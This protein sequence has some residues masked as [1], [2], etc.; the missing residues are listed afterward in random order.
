MLKYKKQSDGSIFS[1]FVNFQKIENNDD[2]L[3]KICL[4]TTE[5]LL[6]GMQ[7]DNLSE[8]LNINLTSSYRDKLEKIFEKF[9][10][11]KEISSN[12][13]L[14]LFYFENKAKCI[15]QNY[16]SLRSS[17]ESFFKDFILL[18]EYKYPSDFIEIKNKLKGKFSKRPG[19]KEIM[20][21]T[22]HP[23]IEIVEENLSFLNFDKHEI[24]EFLDSIEVFK[25]FNPS[26]NENSHDN[27]NASFADI[28]KISENVKKLISLTQKWFGEF[29]WHFKIENVY[30]GK[31][32]KI[33]AGKGW[34]HD[35]PE[36]WLQI[37]DLFDEFKDEYSIIWNSTGINPVIS[38]PVFLY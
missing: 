16:N 15:P 23:L 34:R 35:H 4:D 31:D 37:L 25:L 18:V 12:E 19:K 17:L 2:S 13:T 26:L 21:Y 28:E 24:V 27:Y 20:K 7:I 8:E 1:D 10:W 38:S 33:I 11:E 22:L 5:K 9:G 32:T 3:R 30:G 6:G 36:K 29:P 14:P